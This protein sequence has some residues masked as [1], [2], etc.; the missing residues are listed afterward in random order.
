MKSLCVRPRLTIASCFVVPSGRGTKNTS[1]VL[2][3][4]VNV[5]GSEGRMGAFDWVIYS[6]A[7][8]ESRAEYASGERN[9]IST[10][11]KAVL[12]SATRVASIAVRSRRGPEGGRAATAV[13]ALTARPRRTRGRVRAGRG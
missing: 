12:R 5:A 13:A 9:A 10:A 4:Y 6:G 2:P 11:A 8:S 1:Y 3:L 7:L